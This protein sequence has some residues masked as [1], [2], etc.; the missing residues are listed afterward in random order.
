[1]NEEQLTSGGPEQKTK[2]GFH[3]LFKLEGKG[4]WITYGILRARGE[5]F[6]Y[7][8]EQR[9]L[10]FRAD[11][12]D[13]LE[14]KIG[15]LITVTLEVVPDSHTLTL[16]LLLPKI[17]PPDTPLSTLAIRT[18]HLTSIGGPDLVKGPLQTYDVLLLNGFATQAD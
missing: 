1:M 8:D 3:N 17:N 2:I 15:K 12:I 4:V 14:S 7:R 6:D 16:T 13:S 9:T 5:F 18:K 10:T 11:E